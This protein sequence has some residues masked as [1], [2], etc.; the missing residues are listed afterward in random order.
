M[1]TAVA[2]ALLAPAPEHHTP[3]PPAAPA[4]RSDRRQLLWQSDRLLEQVEQ[5]RLQGRRHL[6]EP[7]R[8][9]LESLA[10]SVSPEVGAPR[11]ATVAAAHRFALALQ[12]RLLRAAPRPRSRSRLLTGGGRW[13]VLELPAG[14]RDDAWLEL[15]ELTVERAL[16]RWR[17]VHDR[18]TAA[19]HQ[20]SRRASLRLWRQ[21]D[22]AWANYWHLAQQLRDELHRC[23][24]HRESYASRDGANQTIE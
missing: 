15:A 20:G 4:S 5:L 21:T 17:L 12:W 2:L 23:R 16:D 13:K 18:A 1:T 19:A 22:A 14:G 24:A 3:R 10:T 11:P 8:R 6:P 7:L 9:E